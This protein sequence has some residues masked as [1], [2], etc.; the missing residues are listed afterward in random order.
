MKLLQDLKSTNSSIDKK[1][2]LTG[3]SY[4]EFR[5]FIYAYS[6][7]LLYGMTFGQVNYDKLGEP[8]DALFDTLD[9]IIDKRVIGNTA[10]DIVSTFAKENGDLIKLV[11]NKDLRCGVSHGLF[12]TVYKHAIPVFNVQLAK[13]VPISD[14]EF[15][16]LAQI[17]YDGVRIIAVNTNGRVKL[18]TRNGKN[19]IL[20]NLI[21][22]LQNLN[23]TDFILDGE[24]VYAEG[25]QEGRSSIS[26]AVNSAMH[27]GTVDESEM[28]Y[29]IFDT[30]PLSEWYAGECN[31]P[32]FKR[33]DKL[34]EI[35]PQDNNYIAI[36]D[37]FEVHKKLQLN[38]LYDGAIA[39]GY[40]GLILKN[41]SHRY[42]F[43]RSKDWIKLKETKSVDLPC[44]G[45]VYGEGKY[46]G[47]IGS[48]LCQGEVEGRKIS[49][50]VGSG[51]TDYDRQKDPCHYVGKTIEVKYNTIV[52]DKEANTY[53]LFLPRFVKVRF[54]K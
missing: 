46:E 12:N 38:E 51:L 10:K 20:P 24:L 54:D 14:V 52:R 34:H 40:E 25:K 21:D 8:T 36:A 28:V 5:T 47:M 32:Y 9:Y 2:R 43:K 15:P 19:V 53:S 37:T 6:P 49:V 17:K 13:E 45:V 1:V 4:N 26:G 41:A 50:C 22:T 11:I 27:G 48:L 16:V 42:T 18:F 30:M 29:Y 33:F 23:C 44:K 31:V 7:Y 3:I 39:I 35:I